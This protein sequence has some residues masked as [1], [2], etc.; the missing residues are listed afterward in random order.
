M[1]HVVDALSLIGEY[2][3]LEADW[4]LEDVMTGISISQAAS[5]LPE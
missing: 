4:M 5:S 2:L 3:R 1:R